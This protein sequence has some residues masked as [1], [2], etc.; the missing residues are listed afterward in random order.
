MAFLTVELAVLTVPQDPIC[1]AA[2]IST[3]DR[4]CH[5]KAAGR[6]QTEGASVSVGAKACIAFARSGAIHG[7]APSV[8]IAVGSGVA[9]TRALAIATITSPVGPMC[10]FA[11]DAVTA[12]LPNNMEHFVVTTDAATGPVSIAVDVLA[13]VSL[14]RGTPA[15][16]TVK[17][18]AGHA[19]TTLHH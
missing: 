13:T 8:S 11:L 18:G 4:R 2:P 15:F 5:V 16:F 17:V 19:R 6:G 14:S 7:V 9:H 3:V 1:R 10:H 12:L